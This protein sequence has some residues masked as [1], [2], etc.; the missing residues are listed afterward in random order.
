MEAVLFYIMALIALVAAVAV[1]S[2]A[3]P[4]M[5]AIW[6]AV[7]FLSLAVLFALLAAPLIAVVH[8]LLSTGS[9][10][11]LFLFV[12]MLTEH[13]ERKRRIMS[14]GK[15]LGAA[16]ASYLA[17]VLIVAIVRAPHIKMP[18]SGEAFEA[19][20]NVGY[21]LLGR[22]LVAF[23]LIGVLILA[24]AVAAVTLAKKRP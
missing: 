12:I 5:S 1:I 11:V 14:F 9:V 23:E 22:Y 16:A 10:V 7:C 24:A 19:P 2:R 18:I 13:G 3:N 8:V 20:A 21:V 15:I 6:L 17:M 4:F